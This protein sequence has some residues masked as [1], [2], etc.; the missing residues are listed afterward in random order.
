MNRLIDYAERVFLIMLSLPF[1][2]NMGLSFSTEPY[3]IAIAVSEMLS[4]VFILI[5]KPGQ[6]ELRAYPVIVAFLGT[7]LPLL[8]RTGGAHLAP[9]AVVAFLMFAGLVVTISAKIAL[10]RS[11]GLIAANRGVKRG[12]PYRFVRHPMYL[13]YF[14]TQVGMLLDSFSLTLAAI[15]FVAWTMQ[16]LRIVEEEKLLMLDADYRRF[17]AQVPRRLFPGF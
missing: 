1:L 10:N 3:L 14:V 13:G 15:Y 16:I 7:S 12:G 17:A 8:A 9:P 4:V 2:I 11:F 6:M 5:R